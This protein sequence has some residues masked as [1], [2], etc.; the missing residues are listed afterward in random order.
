MGDVDG[1][2]LQKWR[3]HPADMWTEPTLAGD[4]TKFKQENL[5]F[6]QHKCG[7]TIL[8]YI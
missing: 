5:R 3:D 8:M 6:N 7:F 1:F 2:D 4:L